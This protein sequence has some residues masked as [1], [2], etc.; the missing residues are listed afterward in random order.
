MGKIIGF[1]YDVR[2]DPEFP[3]GAPA[4]HDAEFDAQETI[5]FVRKAIEACGHTVDCIGGFDQLLNRLPNLGVDIVFNICEG[6]GSRNREAQV[7]V[8]LEKFGIPYV[9]ADGFTMCLTLDKVMTKKMLIAEKIPTPHYMPISKIQDLMNLDHLRFPL[10]AKLRWEGTSKGLSD[11][12][13]VGNVQELNDQVHYLFNTYDNSPVILEELI[14]GAELT[15]PIVGNESAEA[16]PPVQVSIQD[17]LDLGEM[18]Y[19]FERVSSTDLKYV[20]PAQIDKKLDNELRQLALKTYHA[21]DCKDFG[22]VD[23]RVDR[24]GNPYVLEI[25]PLPSLSDEDVFT[26]SPQVAGYDFNTIINKI[27]DAALKRYGIS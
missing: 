21:V 15:V 25:N 19:T 22:R 18:I 1:A 3:V 7:P 27:I 4:D 10:I 5:D 16:L 11:K 6:V 9:G 12:S 17:K 20:C 23:F 8:V 13:V 24:N 26:M 2:K 14:T